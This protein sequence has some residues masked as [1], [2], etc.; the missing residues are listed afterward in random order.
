MLQSKVEGLSASNLCSPLFS[1]QCISKVWP[2]GH[3][4]EAGVL[5]R[6]TEVGGVLP[7]ETNVITTLYILALIQYFFIYIQ[8]Y[9]D[10]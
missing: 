1:K 8:M 9:K 4:A 5:K 10:R 3:R 7:M 6:T 2:E